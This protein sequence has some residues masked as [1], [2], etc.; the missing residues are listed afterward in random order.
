MYR[1]LVNAGWHALQATGHG[2]D[3]ILIGE[4]AAQGFEPGPYPKNTGGLPGNYGQTRPLLFI[5]D[6]YCVNSRFQ[7]L[8]GGAAVATGCPTTAAGSRRF[9]SQ[10]PGL[11]S[12]SG[13]ADHPY[14]GGGSPVSR[15][16]NK[17]DYALFVDLGNLEGTLDRVNRVYG[18]GKHYSIYNTEYGEITNPPNGQS[19]PSPAVAAY[20]IN[21]SEY[22]SWKAGRVASY[23]QYLLEDPPPNQGPYSGFASGLE[24]YDGK[25][26]ATYTAY[27]LP[28][29]MPHTSFSHNANQEIWGD[30]RPAPFMAK[31]GN[32][33]QSVSIQVNGRTI[34]TTPVNGGYFDIRMTFPK[35]RDTVR[36]A[37]TFPKQDAFLPV[38]ELGKTTYSRSFTINVS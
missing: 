2:R 32:G 15:A 21:W 12:A 22:L 26:K 30:A 29:Y 27:Q 7:P 34:K 16:G 20:Y 4:L 10:N 19:Y 31:D 37:Y 35:G 25:P 1:Q 8:R 38:N 17:V 6:L 23:M 18:S 9:R 24:F 33:A 5:R 11:F 13:F 14:D 28:V 3:T 36:L